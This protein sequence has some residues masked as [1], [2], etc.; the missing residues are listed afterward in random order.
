[1]PNVAQNPI[2]AGVPH[3]AFTFDFTFP[4]THVG[5][6][7]GNGG[8]LPTGGPLIA[9]I[10]ALDAGGGLLCSFRV[11]VPIPHTTF[12]GIYDSAGRIASSV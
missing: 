8:K 1:M 5:F 4:R 2:A 3:S 9:S 12:T 7:L 6:F 11:T 10:T